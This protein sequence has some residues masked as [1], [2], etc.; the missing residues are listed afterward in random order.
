MVAMLDVLLVEKS[1]VYSAVWLV[2]LSVDA[3][4]DR[5]DLQ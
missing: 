2:D 5:L 3:K 4:V 1:V